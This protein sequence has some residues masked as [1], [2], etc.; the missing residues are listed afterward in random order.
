MQR[1]VENLIELI[2]AK[3]AANSSDLFFFQSLARQI[4]KNLPLTDKQFKSAKARL[5]H[6][7]EF[8]FKEG[9]DNFNE[10]VSQTANPLRVAN[11]EKSIK[12]VNFVLLDV[13]AKKDN[14][15]FIKI[16]F[17]FNKKEI[18]LV[19]QIS[20]ECPDIRYFKK[21]S[22]HL[23][24]Y[25]DD[26]LYKV[27]KN[28]ADRNFVVDPVLEDAYNKIEFIK[29]NSHM[30]V[31]GIYGNQIKNLHKSTEQALVEEVGALDTSTAIKYLDRKNRFGLEDIK[32]SEELAIS[33]ESYSPCAIK[34]ASRYSNDY[35][36]KPD[37]E[38]LED[39]LSAIVELDRFP[40]LVILSDQVS[41]LVVLDQLTSVHRFF[42]SR[43]G[44][45]AQSVLFRLD[46]KTDT[47]NKSFNDYIKEHKINNWVD[48]STKVVYINYDKLPKVILKSKWMPLATLS[49]SNLNRSVVSTYAESVC[50]LN[51][52]REK[53]F[54]IIK[55]YTKNK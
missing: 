49:F 48:N 23:L 16:K 7:K 20:K 39:L 28:F 11:K 17:P 52:V 29:K 31:P 3:R 55:Q 30:F 51:I 10:S 44:D 46:N 41:P 54:S 34:I 37:E 2:V 33:L 24:S 25:S 36:S 8:F 45:E 5:E 40:L 47:A 14:Q 22:D 35:L 42:S 27:I 4:K 53:D 1:T 21:N 32:F 19:Q 43:I 6:Y 15:N 26:V 9:I 13:L 18:N 12:L 38:K 50:D